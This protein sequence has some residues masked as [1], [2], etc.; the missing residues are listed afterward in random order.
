MIKFSLKCSENHQFE[1]WFGSNADFDRLKTRNLISCA[2]CGGSDVEKA[3]MAPRVPSKNS[4]P[5]TLLSA[6][7]SAAEQA[8]RDM[9]E[10]IEKSAVDVGTNFAAEA[11]KM[12]EGETP[13]R[14]II[15]Q[16]KPEEARRLIEDGVPVIPL[17]W[18]NRRTN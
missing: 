18:S 10:K 15:G 16:A 2:V 9:R 12:H 1:S 3:I 7:A 11:R 17:P 8:V 13:E 4:V 14:S 5:E 6:P